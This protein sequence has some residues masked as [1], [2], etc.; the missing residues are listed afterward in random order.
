[1]RRLGN[2]L[3]LLGAL[4]TLAA[5]CGDPQNPINRVGVNVV[6]KSAFTG[7][8]Y[9]HRTVIDM[10]YEAS[11]LDYVGDNAGDTTAGFL[12]MAIPR[13]R[14][15]IDED[16]LYAYRDYE[17]V[18]DPDDP[19][20]VAGDED[21]DFLGQPV[22]AFRIDSHFDIQRTYNS[23][24]GEQ[25][26]VV[27]E[28]TA[29]RH[30]YERQFMRVDWSSNLISGYYGNSHNLSELFGSVTREPV[31]LFVQDESQF[32]DE[33]RPQFHF[34]SCA[35]TDDA[36]CDANDRDWAADY[37]QGDLYSMSFVTQE[38]LSPGAI[39]PYG[40]ICRW[41]DDIAQ[42]FPDAPECAS[43][44]IWVRTSFLRVSDHRD[45]QPVGWTNDRFNR[46]GIFALDRPTYDRATHAGDP[47]Y[48]F[49]DFTNQSA[50]RHNIW[51]RWFQRTPGPDGVAGN[52]DDEISRDDQ[53]RPLLVPYAERDIR[54]IV[55]YT[56][57]ELPSHLV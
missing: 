47:S 37:R 10:E 31:D 33:Y 2:T 42:F 36:E 14:W 6:E 11:P 22:A 52:D 54:R 43:V 16:F 17:L 5:G 48:G 1:M 53:G 34:M 38:I 13:I 19:F 24:T 27:V 4:V 29:D 56:S 25:Q 44:A 9:M 45:Y 26:N 35:G 46:A 7:S 55:W 41:S 8:W 23:V 18:A 32:P 28:D 12:G 15:V 39:A 49:T 30:W 57:R 20:S 40:T 21:E 3:V 50:N 51:T